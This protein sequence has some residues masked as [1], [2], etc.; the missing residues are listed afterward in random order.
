M[1]AFEKVDEWGVDFTFATLADFNEAKKDGASFDFTCGRLHVKWKDQPGT[2]SWPYTS[3][4]E[5]AF[6][7]QVL[8]VHQ[9]YER[10]NLSQ[11]ANYYDHADAM[12]AIF[13]C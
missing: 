7:I 3:R 12:A 13:E 6:A 11:E 10:W 1:D 4:E 8:E 5:M 9:K 2:H